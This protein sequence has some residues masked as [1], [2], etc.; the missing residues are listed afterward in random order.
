MITGEIRAKLI[1]KTENLLGMKIVDITQPRQGMGSAVLTVRDESG[2]EAVIKF[3][4]DVAGDM[5]VLKLI[6][7]NRVDIPIPTVLGSFV[8]EGKT[9]MVMEK[10]DLPLL[11]DIP[12][13]EKCR[14]IGPMITE[15]RKIH[16][17]K[18][19]IAEVLRAQD[20]TR[21]W[22]ETLLFKYSGNHPWFDW[23]RVKAQEGVDG[24]L[25]QKTIERV[26]IR[27]KQADLP[28][29]DYSLLHTDFNQRNLFVDPNKHRIAGIIDWSEAAF[30]DPLYDFARVRMFIF[31]F[32]I[33]EETEREYFRS[34]DL[35]EEERMRED[36]YL[37]S[38]ILDYITWYCEKKNDF[39]A[40]RLRSHQD[41]LRRRLL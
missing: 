27:I 37:E 20:N 19:D 3:G 4:A 32:N 7:E 6:R 40:G 41:F 30:G 12:D 11:E 33:S 25:V 31:H 14:Y 29:R 10:V 21:S 22:K 13:E 36:M 9:A 18:S 23:Q 8:V 17:I 24:E 16:L 5:R 34:L 15:L 38:Q 39:N 2:W 1:A 35:T 26:K 28:K